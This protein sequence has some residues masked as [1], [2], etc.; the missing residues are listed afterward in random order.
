MNIIIIYSL[1]ISFIIYSVYNLVSSYFFY[2]WIF[3]F[4]GIWFLLNKNKT[5]NKINVEKFNNID[6]KKNSTCNI[7]PNNYNQFPNSLKNLV[8]ESSKIYDSVENVNCNKCTIYNNNCETGTC[9][10]YSYPQYTTTTPNIPNNTLLDN[11]KLV[12]NTKNLDLE[13]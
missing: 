2:I 5:E 4:L 13:Y 11:N 7:T 12:C 8:E 10:F 6:C 1:I 3:T 9:N